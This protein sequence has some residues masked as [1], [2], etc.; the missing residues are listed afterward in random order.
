M[1]LC[2][3]EALIDLLPGPGGALVP[4]PGGSVFNT[5][6]GL[7]R[8]GVPTGFLSGLSTDAYGALLT[9]TLAEAGVGTGLSVRSDRPTARA[10]ARLVGGEARY[11]FQ[12][13]NSAGRL[14]TPDQL[15]ALPLHARTLVFGGIS[16]AS[17]PC[18]SAYESFMLRAAED[19]VTLLD[20]NIRPAF[21]TDPA[22]YR[23]RIARLIAVADIVKLSA[24]DLDW[25]E[26]PGDLATRARAVLARG[27]KVVFVTD[28]AAGAHAFG[29][30]HAVFAPARAVT[31][32]DTV[33]AGDSFNAGAVAA[34]HGMR[35]LS[36]SVLAQLTPMHLR[37][38]LWLGIKAATVTVSRP[39]ASPP[40]LNEL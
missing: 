4:H 30:V 17:E 27:P 16:L 20:P 28:G 23:A 9:A 31:V 29:G 15:P 14:L 40:W 19:R 12:D 11:E 24:E 38:A 35:V 22:A 8:L 39:G 25:L 36:K 13:E 32:V 3:G 7:G 37:A 18:G 21:I 1:I 5:A 10:I 26:G 33:G 6:L 34:L 2:C